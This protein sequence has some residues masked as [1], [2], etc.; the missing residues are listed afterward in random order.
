MGREAARDSPWVTL[1][2]KHSTWRV[3]RGFQNELARTQNLPAEAGLA[4]PRQAVRGF[5]WQTRC[6]QKKI[7]D[8]CERYPETARFPSPQSWA[9]GPPEPPVLAVVQC[10]PFC[11]VSWPLHRTLLVP[12]C[13]Q[14]V[15]RGDCLA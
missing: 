4:G 6:F 10:P 7:D 5:I 15:T 9:L 8:R 13:R 11:I 1:P 3:P 2:C 12:R 14:V